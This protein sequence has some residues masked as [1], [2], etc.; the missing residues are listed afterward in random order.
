MSANAVDPDGDPVTI[1]WYSSLSGYLGTGESITASLT[2]ISDSSQP[3]ITARATDPFGATSEASI[4]IIVWV[5]SD[6]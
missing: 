1:D 4:Q 6:T 5:P 2:T 3:F